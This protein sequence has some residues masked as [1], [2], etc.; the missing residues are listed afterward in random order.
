MMTAVHKKIA[1]KKNTIKDRAA[2][3]PGQH[4]HVDGTVIELDNGDRTFLSIVQDGFS[5]EVLDVT[6]MDTFSGDSILKQLSH[7]I[8]QRQTPMRIFLDDASEYRR[9]SFPQWSA[10]TGVLVWYM[11]CPLTVTIFR[12]LNDHLASSGQL[13]T[14]PDLNQAIRLWMNSYNADMRAFTSGRIR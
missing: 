14:L 10:K 8:E 7:L 12:N 6:P 1:L 3:G 4:W 11:R 2:T 9:K 5:L 13:N